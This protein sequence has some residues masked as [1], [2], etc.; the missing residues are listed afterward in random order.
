MITLK[1]YSPEFKPQWDNFVRESRNATFLFLR[2]YMDYHSDRFRDSSWM[3]YKGG[4]IAAILP[5]NVT[6]DNVLHSHQGLTYGGWILPQR[7]IDGADVLDIFNAAITQWKEEGYVALDYKPL[8]YI[9]ASRPSQED[10]YALFRLGAARVE[11]NLSTAIP[12][13]E[14]C[15][16]NKLRR[17]AL[18]RTSSLQFTI[19]ECEDAAPLMK[20]VSDCLR[21]RHDATPVH[22][23]SEMQL[24]KKRFPKEIKFWLLEMEGE[25]HAAVCVYDTGI[26]AHAQYIATTPYGREQ[27]LLTPLFHHL[28]TIEYAPRAYFD[29][30]TSNEEH[31]NYLNEGLLRQ[32]ASYGATGVAYNRYNIALL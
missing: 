4:K 6:D 11:C 12:L 14:E 24:L 26:V 31:G 27:N 10:E 15:A 5:A 29:F 30:G 23:V 22:S 17:R 16:Y 25:P 32:K 3:A 9:Y 19:T 7:H 1:K 28:I 2:D 18:S 8:P 13:S 20:M 21:D